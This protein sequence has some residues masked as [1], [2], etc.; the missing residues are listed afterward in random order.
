MKCPPAT[1]VARRFAAAAGLVWLLA[2]CA[3]GAP[4]PDW[5]QNA[6]QALSASVTAYLT[7]HDRIAAIEWQ[8]ARTEL[9][10]TARPQALARAEL[11]R[12][13]AR[14]ASLL[15]EDCAGFEQLRID[16]APDDGVYADY[17][18]GRWQTLDAARLPPQHR[19]V[20]GVATDSSTA[21]LATIEDPLAQ[22]VAA[23]GLLRAGRLTPDGLALAVETA[24]AQGW[25]R[26][27]LAWLGL[28]AEQA[29]VA[30]AVAL[31]QRLRRRIELLL[32][33]PPAL[34]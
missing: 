6:Q 19:S 33:A 18:A 29:R 12:C 16:A 17:L 3:G 26:P 7:G 28:Y 2:A 9:A 1:P 32:A 31:Q 10:S 15:L 14:L 8:R 34:P 4:P 21:L 23:A 27:L 22:L 20:P 11:V 24:S 30:G 13:A 5:Q 25:R